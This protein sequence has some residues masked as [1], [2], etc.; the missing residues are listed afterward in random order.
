MGRSKSGET[1]VGV[2]CAS[3]GR[4]CKVAQDAHSFAWVWGAR[5]ADDVIRCARGHGCSK[6]PARDEKRAGRVYLYRYEGH[7][8]TSTQ[9]ADMHELP[10]EL[11]RQR[12]RQGWL[13]ADAVLASVKCPLRRYEAEERSR[14]AVIAAGGVGDERTRAAMSRE[15]RPE[16]ARGAGRV[17]A[18]APA[19]QRS[20][21]T[22]SAVA[23]V[24]RL[25]A[26]TVRRLAHELGS[27]DAVVIRTA[28]RIE[29]QRARDAAPPTKR[30]KTGRRPRGRA[31]LHLVAAEL[32]LSR[33]GLWKAAK[34]NGWSIEREIEARTAEAA[35]DGK[36][37]TA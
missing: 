15:A 11:V 25:E 2:E 37:V 14:R 6:R 35:N 10:P 30:P 29:E 33:Q 7:W 31:P 5:P 4:E 1:W 21:L 36:A 20:A 26:A 28:K 34:R 19:H 8:Y 18:L 17:S 32:G 13:A 3:C 27:L 23:T 24:C 12:L 16:W 9:L 22:V